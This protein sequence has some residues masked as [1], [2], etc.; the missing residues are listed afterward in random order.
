MLLYAEWQMILA[1]LP[2]KMLDTATNGVLYGLRWQVELFI[3]RRLK[4]RSFWRHSLDNALKWV[5]MRNRL[6]LI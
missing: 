5:H 6:A 4:Q 3:N 2:S 1:S